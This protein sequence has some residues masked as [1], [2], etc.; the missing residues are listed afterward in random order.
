MMKLLGTKLTKP[1]KKM[2]PRGETGLEIQKNLMPDMYEVK[3][4]HKS[5]QESSS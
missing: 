4:W 5:V 1:R 3:M 2:D